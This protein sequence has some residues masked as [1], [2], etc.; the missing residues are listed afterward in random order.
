MCRKHFT[1]LFWVMLPFVSLFAQKNPSAWLEANMAEFYGEFEEEF[2]VFDSSFYDNEVFF[3]GELH[4]NW[5][6]QSVDLHFLRHLAVR[7]GLRYYLAEMDPSQAWCVNRYLNTGKSDFLKLVFAQWKKDHSPLATQEHYDKIKSIREMN[8][9]LPQDKRIV[10]LGVDR[11]QGIAPVRVHLEQ[12][13]EGL[14]IKE[15]KNPQLYRLQIQAGEVE[16]Q[17]ASFLAVAKQCQEEMSEDIKG[18]SKLLGDRFW[19][20]RQVLQNLSWYESGEDRSKCLFHNFENVYQNLV[21][22]G[23]KMCGLWDF[24]QVMQ[25]P[26]NGGKLLPLAWQINH[27]DLP[28]FGKVVSLNF[29]YLGSSWL[30]PSEGLPMTWKSQDEPYSVVDQLNNDGPMIFSFGIKN[31]KSL[32]KEEG[33]WFFKLTGE[34]SPFAQLPLRF[35]YAPV[36]PEEYKVRFDEAGK[37]VTDYFQYIILS[38]GAGA[39]KPLK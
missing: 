8:L 24:R 31:L 38:R 15:K 19:E 9:Y 32:T 11:I 26:I 33:T 25:E 20:F 16:G 5:V 22:A 3:L 2:P 39:S 34:E 29:S 35:S 18:Y 12:L 28:C 1:V 6:P 13:L 7:A 17:E 37:N 14:K 23:E 30:L 36:L 21:L 10:Y 4:G 27:S